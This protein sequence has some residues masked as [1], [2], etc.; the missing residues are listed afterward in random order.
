[1]SIEK[2]DGI[3]RRPCAPPPIVE[4]DGFFDASEA[5]VLRSAAKIAATYADRARAAGKEEAA[6]AGMQ[7][8]QL[9]MDRGD[10]AMRSSAEYMGLTADRILTEGAA[11]I[12]NGDLSDYQ[13]KY[14]S[15]LM[16]RANTRDQP[17]GLTREEVRRW[18]SIKGDLDAI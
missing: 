12:E 6:K 2:V 18:R 8:A 1:M 11:L 17:F 9:I 14:V 4:D 7:I 3:D 13:M 15:D 10:D 16:G 5:N